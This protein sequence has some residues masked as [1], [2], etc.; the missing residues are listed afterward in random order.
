MLNGVSSLTLAG[1]RGRAALVTMG[2]RSVPL[3]LAGL[4]LA[5]A[6]AA[7]SA[8]SADVATTQALARA[9]NTLVR[10]A[11]PDIAKALANVQ[12]F[13]NQAAAQCP[14][15]GRGLPAGPR[16]RTARQRGRGGDDRRGV[17]H[18]RR[19]DRDLRARGQGPALEQPQAH[20]RGAGPSRPSLRGSPRWRSQAC[21]A[22]SG[23]GS[24]AATQTL[25]ASTTQFNQRYAAVDPEAEESPLIIRLATPYAT[26]S[27]VPV[28]H[29]VE[30][31]EAQLAEAEAKRR[32]IY[33][34][35]MNSIELKQ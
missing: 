32:R 13:A 8:N 30:R 2:R 26:P 28:L 3:V 21:A 22:T 23:R 12:S 25:P 11:Q 17:P 5:A 34:R 20:A 18:R 29:R 31:F 35:F 19:P 4:A 15:G 33:T 14:H 1:Q 7:A 9:T 6:P 10:A 24:P 27:D 16:L